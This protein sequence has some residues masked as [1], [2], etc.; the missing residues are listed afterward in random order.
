MFSILLFGSK[1]KV[2]PGNALHQHRGSVTVSPVKGSG[3]GR[4]ENWLVS[5]RRRRPLDSRLLLL[6]GWSLDLISRNSFLSPSAKLCTKCVILTSCRLT[7]VCVVVSVDWW[8]LF[9]G[10]GWQSLLLLLLN[11]DSVS[12]ANSRKFT[13]SYCYL[14][15][16]AKE[17]Q[18]LIPLYQNLRV[19]FTEF[20]VA[21]HRELSKV[22]AGLPTLYQQI[23]LFSLIGMGVCSI[24]AG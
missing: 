14:L 10:G 9:W 16:I 22:F 3:F 19:I 12:R 23:A 21:L 7:E 24:C 1:I 8:L 4:T 5:V 18:N 20:G 11:L 15:E 2:V 17:R 6:L 13:C